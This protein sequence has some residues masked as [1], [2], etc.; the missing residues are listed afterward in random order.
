MPSPV[1]QSDL[2]YNCLTTRFGILQ[3][4]Q[5]I[6]CDTPI[7]YDIV[8]MAESEPEIHYSLRR[9]GSST[10]VKRWEAAMGE[11]NSGITT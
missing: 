11:P 3:Q 7:S 2:P 5:E 9:S 10:A 8:N 6:V 4:S 1:K